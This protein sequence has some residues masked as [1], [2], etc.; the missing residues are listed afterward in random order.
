[1]MMIETDISQEYQE[2][3]AQLS[4]HSSDALLSSLPCT[5]DVLAKPQPRSVL[6]LAPAASLHEL[7]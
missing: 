1:M 6:R 7:S 5:G 2:N 3:K 4:Q